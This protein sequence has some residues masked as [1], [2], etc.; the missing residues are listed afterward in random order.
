[1][2][3][4]LLSLSCC[5]R[6]FSRERQA[7]FANPAEF[8]DLGLDAGPRIR[9]VY[10][11]KDVGNNSELLLEGLRH[12][13]SYLHDFRDPFLHTRLGCYGGAATAARAV[14]T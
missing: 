14:L 10:Y 8:N 9:D 6:A 3:V 11:G 2:C 7:K 13:V 5:A 4:E 12:S 1:M